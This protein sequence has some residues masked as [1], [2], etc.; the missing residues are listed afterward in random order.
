[1]VTFFILLHQQPIDALHDV[2]NEDQGRCQWSVLLTVAAGVLGAHVVTR[3]FHKPSSG[4][5]ARTW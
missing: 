2:G 3:L 5:Q 1:M 4:V